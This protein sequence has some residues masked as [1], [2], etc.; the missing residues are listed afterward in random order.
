MT[1]IVP[2][3]HSTA[4]TDRGWQEQWCLMLK[5]RYFEISSRDWFAN[6]GSLSLLISMG[7]PHHGMIS[8]RG[9]FVTP[10][11]TCLE[12]GKT[13]I[14]LLNMQIMTRQCFSPSYWVS[15]MK[16]IIKCSKGQSKGA[17]VWH[18]YYSR[19]IVCCTNNGSFVGLCC[20]CWKT[21]SIPIGINC[22]IH[23]HFAFMISSMRLFS[24][25]GEKSIWQTG[26][27]NRTSPNTILNS[28]SW[29][30][31]HNVLL[32]FCKGLEHSYFSMWADVCLYG[33]R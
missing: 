32:C 33:G 8:L 24:I 29:T 19:D 5:P 27:T 1:F 25:R 28:S 6:Q 26:F 9:I 15:S 4:P 22:H 17:F 2:F 31:P 11:A 10:S 7:S 12:V 13:S 21:H 23:P 20:K 30:S 14:H 18:L 3:S 16:S